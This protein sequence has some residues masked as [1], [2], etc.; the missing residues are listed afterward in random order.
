MTNYTNSTGLLEEP[1]LTTNDVASLA[2]LHPEVIRREIRRGNLK[3]HKLT[4][5]LR[6]SRAA[7]QDW[8]KRNLH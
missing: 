1:L 4:G 2:G 8:L 3:A 6:I 5:R 7:Y